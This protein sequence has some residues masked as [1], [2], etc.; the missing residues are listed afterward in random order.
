MVS[1]E[2]ASIRHEQEARLLNKALEGDLQAAN[3]VVQYLGTTDADL[4]LSIKQT[5]H[6]LFDTNLGAHLLSCL[7][8]HRWDGQ[9]DCESRADPDVSERIDQSVIAVLVED[10]F[11]WETPIKVSVLRLGL[12]D[13]EPR[14]RQAAA[15][16]LGM[17]GDASVIPALEDVLENGKLIW[18][19]RAIQALDIL[20]DERC[21][22]PL[23]RAL[24]HDPDTFYKPALKALRRLG[25][26]AETAW[27]QALRHSNSHIRW[28][29]AQGLGDLG[30]PR[31]MQ[32]LAK[33]LF[34]DDSTVRWAS[35]EILTR[36]GST[37]IPSILEALSAQK[38]LGL[39]RQAVFQVLKGAAFQDRAVQA[40]IQPLLDCLYMPD[41]CI[42]APQLAR[43]LLK[44]WENPPV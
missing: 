4:L 38:R 15:V 13:P 28:H 16:V 21:A 43:R 42:E 6:D 27:Q 17:R 7:G 23:V 24:S 12:Q 40:R 2:K 44:E 31:G 41:A 20:N 14:K 37:V 39:T 36:L 33:G 35:V 1:A 8:I 26:K 32:I 30:D 11:E 22:A 29:A 10:E 9:R 25:S 18:Q 19:F 5:L 34:D 3:N